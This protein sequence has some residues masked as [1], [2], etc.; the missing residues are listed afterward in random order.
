[1]DNT[2]GVE[3]VAAAV[4]AV[5]A[6]LE[7]LGQGIDIIEYSRL[8]H[9]TGIAED[10]LR[11]LFAGEHVS[12]EE[13]DLPFKARLRFLMETRRPKD[14]RKRTYQEVADAVGVDKS[15]I[16]N[17][18]N[19]KRN[20]GFDVSNDLAE[21]FQA[22]GFFTVRPD[23]ALLTAL[24]PTLVQA[25]FI[26]GLKGE[27]VEMVALRG[28]LAAGSDKLARELQLAIQQ[29]VETAKTMNQAATQK[30]APEEDPELRELTDTVS[31]LPE[32]SRKSVLGILRTAVGLARRGEN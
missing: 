16:T 14:G 10:T 28:S 17:L 7:E 19:G 12:P 13:V 9:E 26:A 32:T 5:K 3:G 2:T 15:T 6:E 29:A 8:T 24:E 22:P 18:L 21:Y 31:R 11:K 20:P 25:R 4:A 23:R 27:Q 1:M 30:P